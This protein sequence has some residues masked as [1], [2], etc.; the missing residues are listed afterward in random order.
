MV[1]VRSDEDV[2]NDKDGIPPK[3]KPAKN[4]Q[5]Q[6]EVE[7]FKRELASHQALF[8]KE[9]VI[10]RMMIED[11]KK[12]AEKHQRKI[13]DLE[14]S[15]ESAWQRVMYLEAENAMLKGKDARTKLT[16]T[17]PPKQSVA[18]VDELG[19]LVLYLG[20]DTHSAI[21]ACYLGEGFEVVI[22]LGFDWEGKRVSAL[23]QAQEI[24][25]E[26]I[27]LSALFRDKDQHYIH[28]FLSQ[29]LLQLPVSNKWGVPLV[30]DQLLAIVD[31]GAR[32][33]SHHEMAGDVNKTMPLSLETVRGQ[34]VLD[35]EQL[36][37][38]LAG[39]GVAPLSWVNKGRRL[40]D[41]LEGPQKS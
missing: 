22:R 5:L 36:G 13:N 39:Q 10:F 23:A 4:E 20:A 29:M 40:K 3:S 32:S 31:L 34:P 30:L 16:P 35:E 33:Q 25:K 1:D 41:L 11:M 15:L 9:A 26:E 24:T 27:K 17:K 28:R 38:W 21:G 37:R 14:P 8:R 18:Y 2:R 6:P 19:R 7:T 12:T